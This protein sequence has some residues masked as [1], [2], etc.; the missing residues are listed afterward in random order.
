MT[1]HLVQQNARSMPWAGEKALAPIGE[2]D[3]TGH[4]VGPRTS[5]SSSSPEG[6]DSR[7][8][9][10]YCGAK[11]FGDLGP[12][13]IKPMA[14]AEKD[15]MPEDKQRRSRLPRYTTEDNPCPW[16]IEITEEENATPP[17]VVS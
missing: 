12:F 4:D 10:G 14:H 5:K 8:L 13:H 6:P 11:R 7:I 15:G 1:A 3:S 17:G 16:Q 9:R 2:Q